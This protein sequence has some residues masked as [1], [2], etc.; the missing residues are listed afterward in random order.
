MQVRVRMWPRQETV[1]DLPGEEE[2]L[3]LATFCSSTVLNSIIN[4]VAD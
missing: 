3:D 4:S 2:L 1:T